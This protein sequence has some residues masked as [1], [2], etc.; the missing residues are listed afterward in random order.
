MGAATIVETS[1]RSLVIKGEP[2]VKRIVN[3]SDVK[4]YCQPNPLGGESVELED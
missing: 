4:P 3:R 1:P 2:R